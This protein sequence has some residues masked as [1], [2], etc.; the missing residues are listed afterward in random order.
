MNALTIAR[1]GARPAVASTHHP[2][3][4]NLPGAINVGGYAGQVKSLSDG[5]IEL[6]GPG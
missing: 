3:S 6:G 2:P 1:H 5:A 4:A